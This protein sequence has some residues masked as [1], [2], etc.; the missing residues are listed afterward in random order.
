M[1]PKVFPS[2]FKQRI[3][4]NF[5]QEWF[6]SIENS[7]VLENYSLVKKQFEYENYLD[8][9]PCNL[10]FFYTRLRLSVHPYSSSNWAL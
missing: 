1:N 5:I 7:T 4:D 6:S 9:L 3:I 2:I 8:I 10:R